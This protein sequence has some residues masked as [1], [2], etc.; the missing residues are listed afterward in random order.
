VNHVNPQRETADTQPSTST[1]GAER[2][3]L[4]PWLI[5]GSVSL[6]GLALLAFISLQWAVDRAQRSASAA[7]A[8]AAVSA[9]GAPADSDGPLLPLSFELPSFT[10]LERSG[11]EVGLDDLKGEVWI[12]N[13][14]FT[15]CPGF[16]PA[17][18]E[19]MANVQQR[20]ENH[21]AWDRIRL[22]SVSVDPRTDRPQVLREYARQYD[23]DPERWLF[24]TGER[25]P[26][27]RLIR[28]GFK[29]P[30]AP[31]PQSDG[32]P[33]LHSP[34]FGVVDASG[35]IRGYFEAMNPEKRDRMI[36]AVEK[37]LRE[38]SAAE[39]SDADREDR[40]NA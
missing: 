9:A 31:R 3:S 8:P 22:V 30:V 12:V 10:L 18:S 21:E 4:L 25:E 5:G 23:A 14:I 36:R 11:R 34:R 27:W 20:L 6:V 40:P 32:S 15:E 38:S 37:L 2:R 33:I 24:L 19:A 35:T 1:T 39:A 16:C 7:D 28:D 26:I 29:L 13:F 17:M